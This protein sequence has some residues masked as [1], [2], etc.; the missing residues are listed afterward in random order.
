MLTGKV[1]GDP[2]VSL[3]VMAGNL[4]E[5]VLGFLARIAQLDPDA[6]C[7]FHGVPRTPAD[8]GA[9]HA[10]AELF[11]FAPATRA[12]DYRYGL[13]G[14][15]DHRA[16]LPGFAGASPRALAMDYIDTVEA[17]IALFLQNKPCQIQV[18]LE[19]AATDFTTFWHRI[20]AQGDIAKALEEWKIPHNVSALSEDPP[21]PPTCSSPASGGGQEGEKDP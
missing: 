5:D 21:S 7:S 3:A 1:V 13:S 16:C 2:P 19:S 17:N 11:G 9:C 15:H 14:P 20:A 8:D 10:M 4:L 12:F 6:P 18:R